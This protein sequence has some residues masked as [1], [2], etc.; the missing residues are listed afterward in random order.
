MTGRIEDDSMAKILTFAK[1]ESPQ[2]RSPGI[3]PAEIVFFP[4]VR[5]EYHDERAPPSRNNRRR[6]PRD[7]AEAS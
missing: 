6:K 3:G 1:V 7:A 4:G 2:R 5:V